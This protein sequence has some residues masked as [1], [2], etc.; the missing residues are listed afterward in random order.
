MLQGLKQ[1]AVP[2]FS[3]GLGCAV[4]VL[5]I[6]VWSCFLP[7]SAAKSMTQTIVLVRHGEKPASGLGQLSCRGLNRALALTE[8][9]RH[10]FGRPDAMFAPNPAVQKL[11]G[12]EAYDYVRPLATIEPAA[13][14]F[15]LPVDVSFG[16]GDVA[17]LSHALDA[18]RLRHAV[19][20]VAWEHTEL[21]AIAR[22]LL[23]EH[24]GQQADVPGW[25][26]QDFDG[27]YVVRIRR[28]GDRTFSTF[29]RRAEG[30]N[31]LSPSCPDR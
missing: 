31:G 21:V 17:G 11:D 27:M 5:A 19:V 30:L 4:T 29:E 24:G 2:P 6:L 26:R 12:G 22:L 10:A 16:L 28:E 13:I 1:A 15:G 8:V 20:V 25:D 7:A 14:A 23:A 3:N 9:L 18:A